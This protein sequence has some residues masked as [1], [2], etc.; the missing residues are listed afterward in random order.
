[1][2]IVKVKDEIIGKYETLDEALDIAYAE[3]AINKTHPT[4]KKEEEEK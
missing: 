3:E 1:M 4:V 2:W